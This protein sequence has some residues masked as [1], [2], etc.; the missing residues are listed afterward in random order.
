MTFSETMKW[1]RYNNVRISQ[2][3]QKHPKLLEIFTNLLPEDPPDLRIQRVYRSLF[4]WPKSSDPLRD[5]KCKFLNSSRNKIF[6]KAT[7]SDLIALK[8][9]KLAL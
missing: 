3:P 8:G 2:W 1:T 4:P 9:S 6:K 5:N 7:K